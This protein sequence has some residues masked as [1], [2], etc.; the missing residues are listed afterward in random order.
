[1]SDLHSRLA[2]VARS[3][4]VLVGCDFDGTLA[5]IASE[6]GAAPAEADAVAALAALATVPRTHVAVISGPS[7]KD[8]GASRG[9]PAGGAR[10]S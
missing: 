10:R 9:P 2:E 1:M 8:L 5:P 4:V 7:P 6:P 3:P